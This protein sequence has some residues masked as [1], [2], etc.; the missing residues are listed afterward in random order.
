MV[1][2]FMN[3]CGN[4]AAVLLPVLLPFVPTQFV[5]FVIIGIYIAA[6]LCWASFDAEKEIFDSRET[7][8]AA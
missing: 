7:K 5:L 6:A 3:M 4:F 1:F 8:P 2:S